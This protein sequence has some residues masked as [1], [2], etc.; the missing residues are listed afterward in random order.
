MLWHFYVMHDGSCSQYMVKKNKKLLGLQIPQCTTQALVQI[1]KSLFGDSLLT[2]LPHDASCSPR[3]MNTSLDYNI[4]QASPPCDACWVF[5]A[6]IIFKLQRPSFTTPCYNCSPMMQKFNLKT[7]YHLRETI[8]LCRY[9]KIVH[10][11]KCQA[12]TNH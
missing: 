12:V 4:H 2:A 9:S 7:N 1:D 6:F 10:R 3:I 8:Y 5:L 11:T